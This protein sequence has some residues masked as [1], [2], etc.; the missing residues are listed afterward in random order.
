MALR[1]TTLQLGVISRGQ[2]RTPTGPP[3]PTKPRTSTCPLAVDQVLTAVPAIGAIAFPGIPEAAPGARRY[4]RSML[5]P[6]GVNGDDAELVISELFTNAITHSRSRGGIVGV[7]VYDI[8]T[9]FRVEVIDEG[10]T[11][12]CPVL[13]ERSEAPDS[14]ESG[15]GLRIVAGYA[16]AWGW[17]RRR[18]RSAVLTVVWFEIAAAE[19][20]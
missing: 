19:A 9:A 11:D 3:T 17:E 5:E 4:V 7:S 12:G 1:V 14:V 6:R 2:R 16:K 8:G 20:Q 18:D 15:R 10:N 13:K